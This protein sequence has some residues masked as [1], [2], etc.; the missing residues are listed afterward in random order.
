MTVQ[1]NRV[2]V[3]AVK[4][5]LTHAKWV[6]VEAF[7]DGGTVTGARLGCDAVN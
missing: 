7:G 4:H 5:T 6:L 2:Q 3:Q 1:L